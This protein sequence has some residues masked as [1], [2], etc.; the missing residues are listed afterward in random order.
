MNDSFTIYTLLV[1]LGCLMTGL[2][3]AW[4]LYRGTEHLDKNLRYGLAATRAIAIAGI[5]FL[6]FFPLVRRISYNLQKPIIVIGQ[7]NSL[8]VGSIKPSG[9]NEKQYQKDLQKLAGQLAKSY[10]VKIYNFSDDVKN[11]FDF[12]NKGKLTNGFRFISQLNDQLLN[13]NVGAVILASDGIFNRGGSPLYDINKLKA[14]VYTIA[15]G[16]TVPKKDVLISNINHNSLV[17]LDNEFTI[18]V[19]VQA[20][21]S[22]SEATRLTV[23]ENGRQV[24]ES[25]VEV[26]SNAFVKNVPVKLKASKLGLQKY[27]VQLSPVGNE[28]SERNNLQ[29]IFID[30]IDV[31]QKV[32]IAAAAPHPDIAALK[33]AITLNKYYDLRVALGEELNNININEYSLVILYQ[34][35]DLQNGISPLLSRLQQSNAS[36]WYILGA[37][38]NLNAFNQMQKQVNYSGNSSVLQ[39][40]FGYADPNFTSFDLN[41]LA[42]KAIEDFDPLQSPLGKITIAA[43]ATVALNQRIGKIK[44]GAPLLF[45]TSENGRKTGYLIGEGV[46]RWRL[47]EAQQDQSAGIFNSLISNT[48]QYLAVKDD[49]RKFKAYTAK[50]TFDENENVLINAV[51]YN[52]SYEPVNTPNVNIQLKNAEGKIYNFLFSRTESAYQLDAGTLPAGSYSFTASTILGNKRHAA[53]GVFYVNALMTEYQQTTANHQLLNSMAVQTNG[54]MYMPQDL[55]SVLKDIEGNEQIKTLSYE[56]RKYEELINFKW[57]FALIL[58]LLAMEWFFR[59]RNGE[60]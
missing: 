9:F 56:D 1:L 40:A 25:R 4:L 33:Q 2:F 49:K 53:Q 29:S 59:K 55:L 10:E 16:D 23:M 20:F 47:S 52:D 18:E 46:W 7:D 26:A 60:I 24:Y 31:R 6:L 58:L 3:F 21:E 42:T 38:S 45:F 43:N 48:V 27:T 44:T 5:G 35:P 12:S 50:S 32:L 36:I 39:E 57:L 11:G 30:V 17:Y 41:P 51:L 8:S 14:P 28:I 22:K 37:Q 15:L 13:R 34:L 54:K 19:Q